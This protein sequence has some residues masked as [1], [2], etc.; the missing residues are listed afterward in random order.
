MTNREKLK[1]KIVENGMTQAQLAEILGIRI[2]TLNYKVNNKS[3]FKASE[4]KKLAD[5]LHLSNKEA[6]IIFFANEVE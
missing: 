2:T 3:E 6:N 1:G 4:I 5:V